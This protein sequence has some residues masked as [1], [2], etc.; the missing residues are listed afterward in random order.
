MKRSLLV[1][2]LISAF[3]LLLLSAEP[4]AFGAGNLNNPK[5]YGLTSNEKVI[6]ETKDNLRKV[7]VKSNNQANE[8]DSLRERV[9]GF[10]GIIES[11]S[12][13]AHNNKVNLQKVVE[14]NSLNSLSTQEYEKRL[15]TLVQSNSDSIEKLKVLTSE[16]SILLDSIN[17]HYVSKDEFNALVNDVNNFKTLVAKE[18]DGKSNSSSKS[19]LSSTDNSDIY[20]QAKIDFDKKNYT[21][22]IESYEYLIKKNYKPAY[23]HYMIGEMNYKRKNYSSAISYFKKSS[24]LYSKASYMPSLMLHTAISMEKT[25]DSAHAKAFYEAILSKYADSKEAKYA[26]KNL[27]K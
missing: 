22:A 18:L 21:K 5:P 25:G 24:S 13:K 14:N 15:S 27:N 3:P 6:L 20:N 1:I 2:Q 19:N 8:L 9:D 26:R 4:S 11:L 16:I 7:A 17:T 23:A 10:Q 12:R